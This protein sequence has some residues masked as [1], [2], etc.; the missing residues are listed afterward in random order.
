MNQAIDTIVVLARFEG[1]ERRVCIRK[2]EHEGAFYY[3]L[4]NGR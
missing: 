3:D 4:C 2:G 1:E